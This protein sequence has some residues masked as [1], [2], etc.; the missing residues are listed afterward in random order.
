VTSHPTAARS[1]M[2]SDVTMHRLFNPGPS[3]V[4][5]DTEGHQLGAG[6]F[7]D[8]EVKDDVTTRLI[9]RGSLLDKGTTAK[10]EKAEKES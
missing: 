7:V 8:A 6:R 10:A 5:Y 4:V 3:P 9:E 2:L 1:S